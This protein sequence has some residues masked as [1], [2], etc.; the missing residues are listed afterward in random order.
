MS[1]VR[2]LLVLLVLICVAASASV[3]LAATKGGITPKAPKKGAT[4]AVGS[5]PVF[6]G[7]AAGDGQIWV[8]VS[9]SRKTT[10]LGV[11]RPSKNTL[12]LRA[13]RTKARWALKAPFYDYPQF[14]LNRPG[15]YYWQAHR[16]PRLCKTADCLIEG[17]IVMFKV[18]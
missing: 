15:T 16:V 7:R 2:R 8:R 6:R 12:Q 18:G 3:A 11:I 13:K 4:V 5:Q 14:W 1:R 10:G 9:T 17:P